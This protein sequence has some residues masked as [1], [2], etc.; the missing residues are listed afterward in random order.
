M[1]DISLGVPISSVSE[2]EDDRTTSDVYLVSHG[3][4]VLIANCE[5]RGHFDSSL[6]GVGFKQAASLGNEIVGSSNDFPRY[7]ASVAKHNHEKGKSG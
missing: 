4:T 6:D 2:L 3:R 5:L 7:A 1:S